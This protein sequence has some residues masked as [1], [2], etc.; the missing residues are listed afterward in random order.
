MIN[1]GAYVNAHG[2]GAT[3]LHYACTRGHSECASVLLRAGAAVNAVDLATGDERTPLHKTAYHGSANTAAALLRFEPVL[4]FCD[5]SGTTPLELAE[6]RG[7]EDVA[8]LIRAAEAD[9]GAPS[10]ASG[11]VKPSAAVEARDA[12]SPGLV[13]AGAGR[14]T[15]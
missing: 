8:A 11:T 3:P 1:A 12:A 5:A 2:N 7:H 15:I 4:T 13:L 9:R 10:K 14:S 6:S